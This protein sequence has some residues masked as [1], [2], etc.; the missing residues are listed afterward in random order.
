[1]HTKDPA[2][3]EA[4]ARFM[5]RWSA[6]PM[7]GY[8]EVCSGVPCYGTVCRG[9]AWYDVVSCDMPWY[10]MVW[11]SM[12]WFAMVC[13]GI[14]WYPVVCHGMAWYDEHPLKRLPI[15]NNISLIC[16]DRNSSWIIF[17]IILSFKFYIFIFKEKVW[18]SPDWRLWQTRGRENN[19]K[20]Q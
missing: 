19:L 14:M 17:Y 20:S 2:Y 9:M 4:H 18:R 5:N 11:H 8:A 7:E 1:M 13:H 3:S 12:V 10:A 6:Y 15:R 16:M